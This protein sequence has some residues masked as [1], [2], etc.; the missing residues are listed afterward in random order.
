MQ[1]HHRVVPAGDTGPTAS[2]CGISYVP[3]YRRCVSE[4]KQGSELTV[5]DARAG[6]GKDHEEKKDED[7]VCPGKEG[8]ILIKGGAGWGFGREEVRGEVT[9]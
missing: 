2:A 8:C 6:G 3:A 7:G 5:R 4:V 9:V 1:F